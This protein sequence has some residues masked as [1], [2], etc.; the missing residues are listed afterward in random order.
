LDVAIT[1]SNPVLPVPGRA[2]STFPNEEVDSCP[3]AEAGENSTEADTQKTTQKTA[4]KTAQKTDPCM[5]HSVE[6]RKRNEHL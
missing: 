3:K 2:L 5:V 1:A 6:A 4:Q